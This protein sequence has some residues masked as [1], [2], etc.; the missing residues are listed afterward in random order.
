MPFSNARA[1]SSTGGE[2]R[3]GWSFGL[4]AELGYT[5]AT[6]LEFDDVTEPEPDEDDDDPPIPTR[7][8]SLGALDLSGLELRIGAL[9]RF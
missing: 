6:A 8:L 2:A 7:P 5:F 4:T 1:G 3:R 9:M